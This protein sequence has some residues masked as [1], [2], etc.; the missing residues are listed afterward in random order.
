[1]KALGKGSIAS[2]VEVGLTIAWII[3]WAVLGLWAAATI[4]Y[5]VFMALIGAGVID[6]ASVAAAGSDATFRIRI[7]GVESEA[8]EALQWTDWHFI[9]PALL[10]GGVTIGGSLIIVSRLRR[11]FDSFRSGEPFRRENAQHLR[12]IWI[13]MVVIELARYA[14]LVI[15]GV[16]LSVFGVPESVGEASFTIDSDNLSTWMSIL[17]LIVLAEVFR[18]GAR[19]KE[20]Q[21]L[22]I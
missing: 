16:L 5:L 22:T 20:E 12:V 1:M 14:L 4:G 9:V 2:I 17:I 21:E 10:I 6:A 7:S 18:E 15:V 11:L 13:T 3:L 8:F 19:L